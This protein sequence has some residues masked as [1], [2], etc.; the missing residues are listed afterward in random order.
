MFVGI[1]LN[2]QEAQV[3]VRSDDG[4]LIEGD[5]GQERGLRTTRREGRWRA[6][7]AGSNDELPIHSTSHVYK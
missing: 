5:A 4:E 3:A 7:P 2:K 6:S 1:N